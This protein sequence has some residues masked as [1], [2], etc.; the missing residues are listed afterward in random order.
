MS[1]TASQQPYATKSMNGIITYDDGAGTTI[2]GGVVSTNTIN[3]Q[4]LNI[5]EIQG[6][7]PADNI[8]LYTDTTGDIQ[9]GDNAT[10]LRIG[11]FST[12]TYVT[13]TALNLIGLNNTLIDTTT[14]T[15]IQS[16]NDC[17]ITSTNDNSITSLNNTNITAVA[18][19]IMDASGNT[20][21]GDN[22]VTTD[23][24][25]QTLNLGNT[26]GSN[27]I[28]LGNGTGTNFLYLN[29]KTFTGIYSNLSTGSID[30]QA[31]Q[32]SICSGLGKTVF[33]S[34]IKTTASGLT[35]NGITDFSIG[36]TSA[37]GKVKITGAQRIEPSVPATGLKIG[38]DITS[39]NL[40]LGN[41]TY[42]PICNA[43]ATTGKQIT[44]YDTVFGMIGAG[45]PIIKANEIQTYTAGGTLVITATA[46]TCNAL[47]LAMNSAITFNDFVNVNELTPK[48]GAV[49][50]YLWTAQ[51]NLS[52]I[53]LGSLTA[54]NTGLVN[55]GANNG[56]INIG[57]SNTR[58]ANINIGG[59]TSFSGAIN[60][61]QAT[62]S[63]N[64]IRVGATSFSNI[65]LRGL[66]TTLSGGTATL[67]STTTT[68]N[69]T[70]TNINTTSGTANIGG[71][72]STVVIAGPTVN[73]NATTINIGGAGTTSITLSD[74][75]T[76]TYVYS[77]TTGTNVADTIGN[78]ISATYAGNT[79][80]NLVSGAISP[81]SSVVSITDTG[82]YHFD[83]THS[84]NCTVAGTVTRLLTYVTIKDN[85][86]AFVANLGTQ[87]AY[88]PLPVTSQYA[89][90]SATYVFTSVT[91]AAPWTAQVFLDFAFSSGTYRLSTSDFR[92]TT[93][94]I[95]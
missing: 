49:D 33:I 56:I 2:S 54:A 15:T 40:I 65:L 51:A 19:L 80:V 30:F 46:M 11:D 18:N 93:T 37:L 26:L 20:R 63:A 22:S 66:T 88:G 81:V 87:S 70:T 8:T 29:S 16:G 21:I 47:T 3:L 71:G 35:T 55:I 6:I 5:N 62:G 95:A 69:G 48:T 24:N 27:N 32:V 67:S 4:N 23:V 72:T 83:V 50:L 12:S 52:N 64:T 86:G 17:N 9:F 10:N 53:W 77:F 73:M 82:V 59:G 43:T 89:S 45:N 61:G 38:E 57:N 75:I 25:G 58:T 34:N 68:I 60:I 28:N 90:T 41:A 36:S 44:N 84:Y 14:D 85:T 92:F 7:V 76:P 78:I 42:P 94:R 13:G 74:P 31:N 1:N 79:G 39:A 91:P